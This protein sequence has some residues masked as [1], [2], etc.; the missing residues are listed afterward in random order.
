MTQLFISSHAIARYRA[1]AEPTISFEEARLRLGR[2]AAMGRHRSTARHWMRDSVRA[3][4][5]L[6]FIYW[7]EMPDVCA[8]VRDGTV[9]TVITR[10]MC[11][12]V[13]R[14]NHLRLVPSDGP[15]LRRVDSGA[16]W[17]WSGDVREA[18]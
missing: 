10:Q 1:R 6:S 11:F 8:L 13:R 18:A 17:R 4:P 2:F 15:D 3:T 9:V 5:G 16:R 12:P 7:S 14:P